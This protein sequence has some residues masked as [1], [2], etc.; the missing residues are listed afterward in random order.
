M[1]QT[2]KTRDDT[3]SPFNYSEG[4]H[5]VLFQPRMHI[6]MQDFQPSPP[7]P[8]ESLIA[9]CLL[10]CFLLKV[11]LPHPAGKIRHI[12]LSRGHGIKKGVQFMD[13]VPVSLCNRFKSDASRLLLCYDILLLITFG[14]GVAIWLY[15]CYF[16]WGHIWR[17]IVY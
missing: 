16:I 15:I 7:T 12:H 13:F 2:G 4:L 5:G 1:N 11:C 14:L 17:N 6:L 10:K 9:F 3:Q 8:A